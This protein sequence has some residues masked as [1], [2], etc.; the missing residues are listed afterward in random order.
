MRTTVTLT[1]EAEREVR[2]LMTE[3]GLGFKAAV[4]AAILAGV[5]SQTR[6]ADFPVHAIGVAELGGHK[7]LALAAELDDVE[8]LRTLE[9]G[10]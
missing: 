4:N 7:A 10:R 9:L 2:R 6:D 3:Q 1:P 8:L 5:R